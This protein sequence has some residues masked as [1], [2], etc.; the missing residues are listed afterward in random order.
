MK[1]GSLVLCIKGFP[2]V[3][4]EGEIYT[5]KDILVYPKNDKVVG[6]ILYEI[7]APAPYK[8]FDIKRF[9]E[10]QGPDEV[11]VNAIVEEAIEETIN[12]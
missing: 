2:G 3:V 1:P 8:S 5:I 12:N 11:D 6:L 7:P 10:I 4:E 9:V